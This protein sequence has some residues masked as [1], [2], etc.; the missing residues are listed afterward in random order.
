MFV[1]KFTLGREV[2]Y[3]EDGGVDFWFGF[4]GLFSLGVLEIFRVPVFEIAN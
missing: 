4:G 3:P 2:Y 1:L